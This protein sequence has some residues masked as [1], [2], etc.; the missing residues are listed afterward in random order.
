MSLSLSLKSPCLYCIWS[1][2]ILFSLVICMSYSNMYSKQSTCPEPE[3]VTTS[4]PNSTQVK[5]CQRIL[6][7]GGNP[8]PVRR[9]W[10]QRIT[11]SKVIV[12][13][14]EVGLT[15]VSSSSSHSCWPLRLPS[16]ITFSLSISVV[17]W[18]QTPRSSGSGTRVTHSPRRSSFFSVS[19]PCL[20][21]Y[22]R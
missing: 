8:L 20:R 4:R 7:L 2:L 1:V 15:R 19:P 12:A 14:E 21:S 18:S 10:T 9:S 17:K 6:Y 22:M 13:R 11:E 3:D 5:A 16:L